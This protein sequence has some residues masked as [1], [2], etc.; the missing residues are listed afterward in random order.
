MGPKEGIALIDLLE[1]YEAIIIMADGTFYVSVGL[2][3]G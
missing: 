1:G 3:S 2:T